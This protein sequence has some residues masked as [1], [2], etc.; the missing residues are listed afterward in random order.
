MST[1]YRLLGTHWCSATRQAS[2][3]LA[4]EPWQGQNL[5][6]VLY[7][8][9][10][11]PERGDG[12]FV[13]WTHWYI[14]L[15]HKDWEGIETWANPTNVASL[16]SMWHSFTLSTTSDHPSLK[17]WDIFKKISVFFSSLNR[18]FLNV[19]C[20]SK[21]LTTLA[22]TSQGLFYAQDNVRHLNCIS[23][24][25]NEDTKSSATALP[26]TINKGNTGMNA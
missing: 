24:P 19:S 1:A 5:Q 18:L 11:T 7:L 20:L 26:G 16:I 4:R 14:A 8:I 12:E 17:R 23:S 6:V 25:W 22:V 9:R 21:M 15:Q 3:A 10:K 2:P 13:E